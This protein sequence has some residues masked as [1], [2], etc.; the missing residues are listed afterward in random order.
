MT[1]VFLVSFEGAPDD[2]LL[3]AETAKREKARGAVN[4]EAAESET[5]ERPAERDSAENVEAEVEKATV[6]KEDETSREKALAKEVH[7]PA[8]LPTSHARRTLF[9]RQP[10]IAKFTLSLRRVLP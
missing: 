5:P 3:R 2:P 8:F 4:D 9:P 10:L 7:N 6:P 1:H